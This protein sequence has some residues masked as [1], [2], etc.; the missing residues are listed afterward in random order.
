MCGRYGQGSG[1]GRIS[2]PRLSPVTTWPQG[3]LTGITQPQAQDLRVGE[4]LGAGV[5]R[6]DSLRHSAPKNHSPSEFG[7]NLYISHLPVS[8]WGEKVGADASLVA[9]RVLRLQHTISLERSLP[10]PT[11]QAHLDRSDQSTHWIIL[12]LWTPLPLNRVAIHSGKRCKNKTGRNTAA[13]KTGF[14]RSQGQ[15]ML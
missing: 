2:V 4:S 8:P 10:E 1:E 15:H 12:G 11:M 5:P 7:S 9:S 14:P 6:E 3:H 13:D